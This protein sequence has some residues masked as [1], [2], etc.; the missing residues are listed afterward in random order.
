M[1]HALRFGIALPILRGATYL[2]DQPCP[3]DPEYDVVVYGGTPGGIAA[4]VQAARVGKRVV[5]IDDSIVRGTTSKK[6][7]RMVRNASAQEV[8]MRISCPPTI[9]LS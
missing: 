9:F 1:I 4:A 5:L 6:I 3:A 8:H 2:V 7:V